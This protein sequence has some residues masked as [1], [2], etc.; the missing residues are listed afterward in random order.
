MAPGSR[1]LDVGCGTGIWALSLVEKLGHTSLVHGIDLDVKAV[2]AAEKRRATH[3]LK[4]CVRFKCTD[5]FDHE[6]DEP[7]DAIIL[8]NSLSYFPKP[9]AVLGH[10]VNFV[11]PNGVVY[12]KDSDLGSDFFWPVDM[13]LYH[14]LMSKI[15]NAS[16]NG[17]N[18]SYDP[19]FARKIPALLRHA[20]FSDIGLTSQSFSFSFPVDDK[21]RTYIAENGKMIADYALR[22]GDVEGAN[23]WSL[24]FDSNSPNSVFEDP[25]FLYSMTEFIF[26]ARM[27]ANS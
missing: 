27:P 4:D 7:Y 18:G 21:Q 1:V 23:S 2:E 8:F 5:I 24:Q 20:G 10:L 11:S 25:N 13:E 16:S 15:S 22:T 26:Q 6:P 12:V 9:E 19:F 17:H 3:F 14:Q